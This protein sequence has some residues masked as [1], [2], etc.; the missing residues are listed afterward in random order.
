VSP[1]PASA[2]TREPADLPPPRRAII[3]GG[4]LAGI[5]AAIRLHDAGLEVRLLEARDRLGGRAGSFRDPATGDAIDNCQHV[6][7]GCCTNLLAFYRRLGVLDRIRWF[8]SLHFAWRDAADH[9]SVGRADDSAPRF[10]VQ[11]FR[12]ASRLPAP[13]HLVPPFLALRAFGPGD[14][15]RLA[16]GMRDLL[17]ADIERLEPDLTFGAWLRRREQPNHLVERYWNVIIRS[18]CNLAADRVA[19]R[20]AVQVFQQGFL[21]HGDAWRM[22]LSTVPLV[23]LYDEAARHLDDVRF[24]RRVTAIEIDEDARRITA[25]RTQDGS[26]HLIYEDWSPINAKQ[27]SWDSPPAGHADSQNGIDGFEPKAIRGSPSVRRWA[28]ARSSAY[29]SPSSVPSTICPPTSPSS[30]APPAT[31]SSCTR[32]VIGSTRSSVPPTTSRHGPRR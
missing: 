22:G 23:D 3:L 1:E 16:L 32:A 20:H 28:T 24:R 9:G 19:A 31:G 26:F 7:L 25:I 21:A 29:T 30:T 2:P 18:A 10:A 4:G 11:A 17:A 8:D 12:P 15:T 5:A 6:L 13:L 27:H 14:K